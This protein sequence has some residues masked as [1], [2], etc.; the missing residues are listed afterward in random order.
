MK[1]S[2]TRELLVLLL[3]VASVVASFACGPGAKFELGSLNVS[4][5][6]V[7]KDSSLVVSVD[8]TNAGK[9]EGNFEARLKIDNALQETKTVSVAVGSTE[10]VSFTVTADT[11]GTHS[12]KINDFAGTFDVLTPPQFANLVISP[13]QVKVGEPA[14]V[15]ADV[16]NAGEISGNYTISLRVND[17]D[18]ETRTM[19]IGAGETETASFTLT[20]STSGTY[21]I[22]LGGL[23]GSLTVLKP[24]GFAMSNLV[25]SPAQAIAGREVTIMCDVTNTGG[26]DGNCPV[27]LKV[28][29]AQVDS[30]EVAVAAGATQTVAFSLV[31]DIG[32]TY[33]V[34]IG[35]LSSTLVVSEGV[36]PTLHVG[37]Q[38]VYRQIEK[39]IAYTRTETITGEEK[40][41]GKSCFVVKVTFD[42]PWNG[43]I[44]ERTE[45]WDKATYNTVRGQF[46]AWSSSIGE[47]VNRSIVYSDQTTGSEW[48]YKVGNEFTEKVSWTITDVVGGRS[49][50][51]TG[52]Y[53][54]T[55][56]VTAIED[57]TI[58]AGTFRCFKTVAYID[59]SPA[60]EYWYSD[61]AKDYL[62]Y[63]D[64]ES[65]YTEELLSYSVR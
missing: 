32:G 47:T 33:N 5:A 39:G 64:L 45:W 63:N 8:V 40:M 34:A 3:I 16:T 59:G 31:K 15:F 36:L 55:C 22:S 9:A 12:V 21:N 17:T 60:Y 43:W 27:N 53:T 6:Q 48:P 37:D 54:A 41:E 56:K 42:P 58:G 35:D 4:P 23:S 2:P 13:A 20:R 29:G 24:A 50:S 30:K 61:K 65:Q 26:V 51:D 25:I 19:A 14:T 18:E 10:T 7:V 1:R 38:W 44:P 28:D 49:Y 57:I 46:S 11:A 52:E 62:K